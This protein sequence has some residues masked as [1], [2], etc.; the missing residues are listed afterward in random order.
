MDDMN[1]PRPAPALAA[2]VQAITIVKDGGRLID[3]EGLP[4]ICAVNTHDRHWLG[5]VTRV[6]RAGG[7][8]RY[9]DGPDEMRRPSDLTEAIFSRQLRETVLREINP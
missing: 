9:W 5:R 4:L 6:T 2:A 1:Q 3:C 8:M 7:R